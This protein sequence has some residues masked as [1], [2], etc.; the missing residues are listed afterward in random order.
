MVMLRLL[1]LSLPLHT[2]VVASTPAH[3]CSLD[4]TCEIEG[5]QLLQT[6]QERRLPA[7]SEAKSKIAPEKETNQQQQKQQQEQQQQKWL[8]SGELSFDLPSA[9]KSKSELLLQSNSSGVSYENP[10]MEDAAAA[11]SAMNKNGVP[12][13]IAKGA[14]FP[15]DGFTDYIPP[16]TSHLEGIA[17][18]PPNTGGTYI[19]LTG[20]GEKPYI[21]VAQLPEV[22]AAAGKIASAANLNG[23]IVETF[24][25]DEKYSHP[26]GVSM[27]G[28]ILIVGVEAGCSAMSRVFGGCTKASVVRFY[29]LSDPKNPKRLP[30]SIERPTETA[31]AVSVVR[32]QNGKFL[33]MV[34][35][36]DSAVIDFYVSTTT[37]GD[38]SKDP[39]FV[40][41]GTWKKENLIGAGS[42][43]SYQSLQL[44][45]QNNGE[46]FFVGSTRSPLLIGHDYF[47]L[48]RLAPGSG[49]IQVMQVLSKP[50]VGTGVDFAAAAAVYIDSPTSLLGYASYWNPAFG[51]GNIA[52]NEF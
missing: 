28:D 25:P 8:E 38:L 37:D 7:K 48:Y 49:G 32:Q 27:S 52:C 36:G 19:A 46:L 29:D 44:I 23:K 47:D 42:W 34:G 31:G 13:N 4:G 3:G 10:K 33:L 12:F 20:A 35:E 30:Y 1:A 41:V 40:Q 9:S 2:V 22:P 14:N 43:R 26:G 17:R 6:K 50:M 21:F 24:Q 51:T 5:V 15:T 11:L 39:G 16:Y 18:L 45:L